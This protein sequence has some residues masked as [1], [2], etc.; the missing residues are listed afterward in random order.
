MCN[1]LSD[2][3]ADDVDADQ[4]PE[5]DVPVPAA[6]SFAAKTTGDAY[7]ACIEVVAATFQ[8]HHTRSYFHYIFL[9]LSI[10]LN[11]HYEWVCRSCDLRSLS[12]SQIYIF[13]V[14]EHTCMEIM[15]SAG[16]TESTI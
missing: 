4:T 13:F 12:R 11:D 3:E 2:S 9:M 15:L 5:A 1:N 7:Y 6:G 8:E 14:Y 16:S 10:R